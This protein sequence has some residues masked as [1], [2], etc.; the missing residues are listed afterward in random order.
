[1]TEIHPVLGRHRYLIVGAGPAGLQ[2]SYYLQQRGCDY[3]T[4]EREAAPAAFF[5]H[6]PRHRRLISINKV[7]TTS[8]DPEIRLRWDWNSLLHEPADLPFPKYSGEYFPHA[9]DLVRYLEDF[10]AHHQLRVR[11]DTGV[12]RVERD[13]DGFLVYTD[14]G[15][16]AAD[17][18]VM[19]TGWQRPNVPQIKGIEHVTGYES[20]ETDP[21]HYAN[22]RVLIL[23][24]GNSAFETASSMLGHAAMIH[25]A[26]P[27]PLRLSWNTKHPGDVRGHHGA[28]LDSYQFKTLH[29]V[30]DCTI[31]EIVPLENGNLEVHLTYT[32][33]DGETAVMEYESV[34]RCTGFAMDT[35][36]FGDDCRPDLVPSGR[37]PTTR[38]DWQSTNVD[39]LYFAGTL[40]QDRDFKKASSAFIDGFRYNLR[41]LTALLV[42]RYEQTPLPHDTTKADPATLTDLVLDRVNWS[43]A[44]WTQFEFLVD[45]L[46]VD[47]AT[48][49]VRH[50][51]DLPEDYAVARFADE[52]H[53]YTFGLRWGRDEY[54]D[55]FA[56]E[57]HPQPDR[58]AESAFIHPVV[59][60]YHGTTRVEELHLLEDLLAEWRRP[61]RHV[62]PLRDFFTAQLPHA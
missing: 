45:A 62:N 49:Q 30:L 23:G 8:T 9:D 42:E 14:Q 59:R 2:L 13:G 32:H 58:A 40:A 31:D 10:T 44:L 47:A 4:L 33:A 15:T 41:T 46:V 19:A 38:P 53:F 43:S 3:L 37:M 35:S 27:R 22:Q 25:L 17:C 48:G 20:M 21:A 52:P 29:S 5:R 55:V 24:K 51:V 7:H 12:T 1:M 39:G 54:G 18:L 34:L 61:E 36:V 50:Y 26:S 16:Y 28:V 60:R 11:Y 56:I 6:F 57:R